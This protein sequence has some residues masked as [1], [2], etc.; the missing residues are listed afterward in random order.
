L[1]PGFVS[2]WDYAELVKKRLLR[3]TAALETAGVP[4]AVVGGHAVAAWVRWKDLGGERNTPDIDILLHRV[5][6]SDARAALEQAGFVRTVGEGFERFL[7]GPNARP[8][9]CIKLFFANEYVR[10]AIGNAHGLA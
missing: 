1:K 7:D 9:N 5:N 6:H 3:A 2:V 8:K 10:I 4:D